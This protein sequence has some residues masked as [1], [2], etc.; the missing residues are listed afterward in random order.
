VHGERDVTDGER[1]AELF[2]EATESES[3]LHG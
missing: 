1:G 3:W 2:R